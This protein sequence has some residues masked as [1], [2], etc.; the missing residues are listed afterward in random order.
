MTTKPL[1]VLCKRV[2]R[3]LNGT[4]YTW[5]VVL[6]IDL[7][8]CEVHLSRETCRV[9]DCL[10]KNIF[11]LIEKPKPSWQIQQHLWKWIG[12]RLSMLKTLKRIKP[13]CLSLKERKDL[14]NDS[15]L[16][17]KFRILVCFVFKHFPW[18][19]S[20]FGFFSSL[21]KKG[22]YK[23]KNQ[24][25]NECKFVTSQQERVLLQSYQED[26]SRRLI[27]SLLQAFSW[28]LLFVFVSFL[29]PETKQ[30]RN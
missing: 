10:Q 24:K 12:E 6:Y 3:R 18:R 19:N 13:H 4:V 29:V 20:G 15:D 16:L 5:Q 17:I 21:K 1:F 26:E 28:L 30:K 7:I 8:T 23:K 9:F 11:Q 27:P 22:K 25:T 14:F 2:E